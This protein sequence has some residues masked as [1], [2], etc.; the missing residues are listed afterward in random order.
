MIM[1]VF[2]TTSKTETTWKE[3]IMTTVTTR[4]TIGV[5]IHTVATSRIFMDLRITIRL[6][7]A[8]TISTVIHSGPVTDTGSA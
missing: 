2:R 1:I 5:R 4:T 6:I 3:T 8:M 7:P